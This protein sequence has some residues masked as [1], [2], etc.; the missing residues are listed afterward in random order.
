[1]TQVASQSVRSG[2]ILPRIL[3]HRSL[4]SSSFITM[5]T[6]LS[7]QALTLVTGAL[8]ARL[9]GVEGRGAFAACTVLPAVVLTLGNLGGPISLTYFSAI[10]PKQTPQLTKNA[11][12][13]G[14]IGGTLLSGLL[15]L[16]YP[17]FLHRYPDLLAL[18]IIPACVALPLQ[19][20][21][22][23]VNAVT[24]GS[25]NLIQF[26][27]VRL[28]GPLTYCL[29]VAG[30]YVADIDSL[31]IVLWAPAAGSIAVFAAVALLRKPLNSSAI[32]WK[33]ARNTYTYGLKAHLGNMT[34]IDSL[35]VDLIVV[36]AFLTPTD[37]GLYAVAVAVASVVRSQA[38][39]IGLVA[40][41]TIARQATR[42]SAIRYARM[43]FLGTLALV[44]ALTLVLMLVLRPA[45]GLVYGS[46]FVDAASVTSVLLVAMI[47]ASIRQSL[48]DISRALGFPGIGSI[49]EGFTWIAA[50]LLLPLLVRS[51]GLMGAAIAVLIAYATSLTVTIVLLA[52]RL[53]SVR[54]LIS[55]PTSPSSRV[56]ESSNHAG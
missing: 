44:L 23:Q 2:G 36:V 37:A 33:L 45:L 6:G 11:L 41:P 53:L 52:R 32:D 15:A 55:G 7:M 30:L 47:F 27:L 19:L 12:V 39:T 20:M 42:D 35:R 10:L 50:A 14:L 56:R 46:G 31:A 8:T 25:G 38:N 4:I 26:N 13:T 48:G 28:L 29:A 5:A 22:S 54:L 24:Q 16:L 9:L 40:V 1:M 49:A 51:E 3:E 18:A 17:F 21:S 34:A 43:F